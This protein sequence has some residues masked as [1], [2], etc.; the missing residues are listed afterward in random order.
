MKRRIITAAALV[1]MLWCL[2]AC[3]QNTPHTPQNAETA[4]TEDSTPRTGWQEEDGRQVY[5]LEDGSLASGWITLDGVLHYFRENGTLASGWVNIQG[6]RCYFND[7]GTPAAG[8]KQ[9]SGNMYYLNNNGVPVTGWQELDGNRY[10]FDTS[11]MMSTG[12]VE[13]SSNRYYFYEDGTMAAGAVTIS[14]ATEYFTASGIY[15]P[16]VNPWRSLP[17]DYTVNLLPIDDSQYIEASCYSALMKMLNACEEAGY[18]PVVC[19]AYRTNSYQEYLYQRKV[20]FYLQQDYE[21]EEA[22][23]L[24]ATV[25]ARP[26]TS[27]HQLGLAVDIVDAKYPYL[28]EQQEDTATQQWLMEHCW[29][30][31]FI[32]RYPVG[33]MESTGIIYE[34]WHYRYVGLEVA[35]EVNALGVTLEEYLGFSAE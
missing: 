7:D 22:E 15:V 3:S 11:G 8:W 29:E 23:T 14:G 5:Y 32:L 33:T 9:I 34:P 18:R 20:D 24:A 10:Y 30:Y 25:V 26:G 35:K 12:W 2:A 6:T 21:Q 19:S 27:E 13:I 31:G 16:L 1:L 28:D 4:G 17:E